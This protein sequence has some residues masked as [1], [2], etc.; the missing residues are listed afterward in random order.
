MSRNEK[1][2]G[3]EDLNPGLLHARTNEAGRGLMEMRVE[4]DGTMGV[5][6]WGWGGINEMG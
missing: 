6:G 1:N 3:W 2:R 4:I 5:R